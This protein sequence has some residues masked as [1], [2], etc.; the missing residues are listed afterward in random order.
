MFTTE[1]AR[2]LL[3]D[4][5]E[6]EALVLGGLVATGGIEDELVWRAVR[7]LDAIRTRALRS[8]EEKEADRVGRNRPDGVDPD[9]HPAIE[10]FL[11]KIRRT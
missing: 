7:G 2:D 6:Q 9:P 1:E 4:V 5:F 11:L 3:D 8:L 10:E